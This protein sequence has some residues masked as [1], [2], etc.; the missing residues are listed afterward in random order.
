MD[1]IRYSR[2]IAIPEIGAE[3]QQRLLSGSVLVVGC[4]ALGSI[5]A[6]YLSASGVGRIGIADFDTIDLSNLQRQVMYATADAGKRKSSVLAEK[7]RGLNP[8]VEVD[9]I[10]M[11][12]RPADASRLF[13]DYDFI[14]DGSD[15]PDTKFMTSRE[16]EQLQKP[17]CI[18]GIRGFRGQLM[19]WLP[20]CVAY[21]E[22]FSEGVEEG[23][24][25]CST[26]GVFGPATGM[27]GAM[28]AGEAL[29]FLSGAGELLTDRL[30]EFNLLTMNFRVVDF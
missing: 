24:L 12:V 16:C 26:E 15:N 2:N 1:K 3:G 11:M 8:D 9:E 18:G 23:M 14:L 21:H 4:G 22:L 20:G 25:P 13:S 27:L 5:A 19:S 30:L 10:K 17:C 29:K 7:L 28:Q 6:T